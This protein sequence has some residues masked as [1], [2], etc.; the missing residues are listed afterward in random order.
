MSNNS[1]QRR[2]D[3]EKAAAARPFPSAEED[4]R[5]I[6]LDADT[7]QTRSSAYRLGYADIDFIMRDELRA[8]RL[9]LEFLKAEILQRDRGISATVVMF[10][11][12]RV[13]APEEAKDMLA[14]ATRLREAN[15]GDP[16]AIQRERA[17]RSLAAK[18]RYY[19]EA[20][21]LASMISR[22]MNAGRRRTPASTHTA[23]IVWWW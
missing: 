12:A 11:S 6:G 8:S 18:T 4:R 21:M 20:R 15:P 7:P 10:G 1:H 9:Q 5:R 2:A 16:A 22:A 14:E 23:G 17:V 13:P 19:D 3:P